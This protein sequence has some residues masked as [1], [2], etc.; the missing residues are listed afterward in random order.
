MYVYPQLYPDL[1]FL[2]SLLAFYIFISFIYLYIQKIIDLKLLIT[3]TI[4]QTKNLV[5]IQ[6]RRSRYMFY[7]NVIEVI[8]LLQIGNY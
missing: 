3:L 7:P 8:F 2:T 1:Q 4:Y 6:Y 5:Q